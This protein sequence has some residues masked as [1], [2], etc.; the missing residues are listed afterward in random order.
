MTNQTTKF[1]PAGEGPGNTGTTTVIEQ[2]V[3]PGNFHIV[4]GNGKILNSLPINTVTNQAIYTATYTTKDIGIKTVG[5]QFTGNASS[6]AGGKDSFTLQVADANGMNATA[7]QVPGVAQAVAGPGIWVSA[8]NGQGVVTISTYPLDIQHSTA[9]LHSVSWTP[10]AKNLPWGTV[11]QFTA[12]GYRGVNFRS[13]D[14]NN[15]VRLHDNTATI[16]ELYGVAGVVNNSITP[17]QT[18]YWAVGISNIKTTSTVVFNELTGDDA[19]AYQA[20]VA[21]GKVGINY[22]GMLATNTMT[23]QYG[24]ISNPVQVT[25]NASWAAK[26]YEYPIGTYVVPY[27][28]GTGQ[29]VFTIGDSGG[30][31]YGKPTS[32]TT[33]ETPRPELGYVPNWNALAHNQDP[34]GLTGYTAIAVGVD[35]IPNTAYNGGSAETFVIERGGIIYRSNRGYS[36]AAWGP[37]YSSPNVLYGVAYG[38]GTWVVVGDSN[39]VIR[40]TDSTSWTTSTGAMPGC[41]WADIAYGN[42][43]F[44][45]IGNTTID[46]VFQGAI[47]YSTDAGLT[48][49]K[50]NPGTKNV[51]RSIAY[52]PDLN[53]FAAVGDGGA[54]VSVPG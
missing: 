38:T 39:I 22:D 40:S 24:I 6:K 18:E 42:G 30:I 52:S 28:G 43:K 34:N 2:P 21:Y 36:T 8:P 49:T 37:I 15:F 17:W 7:S 29:D 5:V 35:N 16:R 54:I 10:M 1:Y 19:F 47:M 23:D 46:G 44:V 33:R 13:R 41:L 32:T 3:D 11:G 14:G 12:V 4:D 53:I 9:T 25:L 48:W 51:L 26:F 31:W 50:G 45:A 27:N 20:V